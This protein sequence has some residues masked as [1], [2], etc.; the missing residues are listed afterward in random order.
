[1]NKN[2]MSRIKEVDKPNGQSKTYRC[3]VIYLTFKFPFWVEI[4]DLRN[5]KLI[6]KSNSSII[7]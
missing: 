1:M 2:K 6:I 5:S 7:F 4:I 3:R